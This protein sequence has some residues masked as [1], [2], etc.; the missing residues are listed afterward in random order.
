MPRPILALLA[1]A[2]LVPLVTGE[3]PTPYAPS[4]VKVQ[5]VEPT[6]AVVE[7]V[8]GPEMAESYRVY[9]VEGATL[10]L[11]MDT[12]EGL[13]PLSLAV[14]VPAAFSAYAVSGVVSGIE[15]TRVFA[16]PGL[17]CIYVQTDPPPPRIHED[18]CKLGPALDIRQP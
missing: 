3:A 4:S 17:G 1:A 16:E 6:S 11:L 18:G 7:W 10:T 2:L 9:G 12:S 14:V 8:P 5:A 13:G 15:S